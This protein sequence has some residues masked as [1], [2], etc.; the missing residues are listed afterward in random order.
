MTKKLF[1]VEITYKR[2]PM[3]NQ[4]PITP[5]RELAQQ[6][7]DQIYGGPGA[8]VGS[9]DLCLAKL[10]AQWGADQELEACVEW[11]AVYPGLEHP[12]LLIEKLRAARRPQPLSL[13]EQ[14]L[15]DLSEIGSH[16]IGPGTA[17]RI[18]TIRRALEALP[19]D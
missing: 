19:N 12:E 11:L 1:A 3:T 17:E 10:A 18:D 16:Y 14:A 9:D 15:A 13:K 4:H 7:T 2:H 8:V 6:W 5:S